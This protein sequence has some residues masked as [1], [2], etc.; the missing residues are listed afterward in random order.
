MLLNKHRF[1]LLVALATVSAAARGP[2]AAQEPAAPTRPPSASASSCARPASSSA[3]APARRSTR[4]S[5][6]RS[7]S[8]CGS[9]STSPTGCR[10]GRLR[11]LRRRAGRD[12]LPGQGRRLAGRSDRRRNVQREPTPAEAEGRPAADLEH[13][14]RAAGVRR[15]SPGKYSLFGKLFANYDFYGFGGPGV[16]EREAAANRWRAVRSGRLRPTPGEP[17]PATSAASAGSKLGANV[18]RRLPQLLRPAGGAERRAARHAWRSST[19]RAATSTATAWPT[20]NDL[21]WTHTFVRDGQPDRS[22]C[23]PRAK[24]SP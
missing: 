16:H 3:P 8:T 15:R 4:T 19:R 18:R 9:P 23:R 1:A 5:I 24:I 22:S 7:W 17:G 14:R 13:P 12:R 10:I 6:T 11:R 21:S 2:G 20:T